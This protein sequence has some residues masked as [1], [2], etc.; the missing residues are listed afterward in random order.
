[1]RVAGVDFTS[2]PRPR[3]PITVALADA[4]SA[5]DATLRLARIDALADFASFEAW[6]REPGPWVA[7][8]DFPFGFARDFVAAQGWPLDGPDAWAGIVGRV[9]ALTRAELVGRCRAWCD[10]RPVGDKFAHRACDATAGSSASMKWVNPPVALML[11][12]G[13]PRLLAAGVTLPGLHERGTDPARVALE[14]YP[15]LPARAV[16]GRASYKS[17]DPRHRDC[18]ARRAGRER[19]VAALEAGAHPFGLR[20][21]FGAERARCV[22]EPGADRLDAVLCMVQ[23]AWARERRDAHWGLPVREDRIEG[24]I[25]GA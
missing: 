24:W 17:D 3:K 12:A 23:A 11:H 10:A 5:G 21:D 18:D 19:L 15:G 4:P 2:A 16:L 8:F 22:E 14:G 13:A 6:L 1:M 25:V 7:A 9:A 20:V